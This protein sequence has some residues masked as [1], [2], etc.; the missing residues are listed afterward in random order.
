MEFFVQSEFIIFTERKGIRMG[1]FPQI[2]CGKKQQ[3]WKSGS[4]AP[5]P[6]SCITQ[7]QVQCSWDKAQKLLSLRKLLELKAGKISFISGV[8]QKT[9]GV[10]GHKQSSQ[11]KLLLTTRV[12]YA[13]MKAASTFSIQ[14]NCTAGADARNGSVHKKHQHCYFEKKNVSLIITTTISQHEL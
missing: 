14:T 12:L 10:F 9:L 5:L 4:G 3:E 1:F 8:L 11:E 6:F 7:L 13:H 2:L